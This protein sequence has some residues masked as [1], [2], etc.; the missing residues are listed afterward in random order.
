[1]TLYKDRYR[2]E[3]AR[4]KDWDYASAGYYFVTICTRDRLCTLGDVV[5]GCIRL[6]PVGEMARTIWQEIPDHVQVAELDEFVIMPNHLHG[7]VVIQDVRDVRRD[8]ACYVSTVASTGTG[9]TGADSP[10]GGAPTSAMALISP[11]TGSLGAIIRS[12]KSAVTHWCRKNDHDFAWQARFHDE[13]IRDENMLDRIR[14]YICN[15]PLQWELDQNNPLN[16]R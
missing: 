14:E 12:Y 13:I 2:A 1:M 11:K 8:V 10:T 3:S 16:I 15:N 5:D 4:L 7:I 9:N 6:S